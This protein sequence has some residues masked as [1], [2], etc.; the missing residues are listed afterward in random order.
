MQDSK[1]ETN[2]TKRENNLDL[3]KVIATIFMIICH[4]VM[5]L[6]SHRVGYESEFVYLLGMVF[7]YWFDYL[8]GIVLTIVSI[9]LGDII[10]KKKWLEKIRIGQPIKKDIK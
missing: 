6:G 10:S 1:V 8:I 2:Q 7:P 3:L 5:M 9:L 4:A